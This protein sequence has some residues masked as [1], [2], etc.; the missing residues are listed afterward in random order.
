MILS[1][2]PPSPAGLG[3]TGTVD[4]ANIG[5]ASCD[6]R[7]LQSPAVK[8]VRSCACRHAASTALLS[9][10]RCELRAAGGVISHRRLLSAARGLRPDGDIC[11]WPLATL[12][13]AIRAGLLRNAAWF[14]F[15]GDFG[16]SHWQ[17]PFWSRG[18]WTLPSRFRCCGTSSQK[19]A[20]LKCQAP[21]APQSAA[22]SWALSSGHSGWGRAGLSSRSLSGS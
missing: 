15:N 17:V 19:G 20:R 18:R 7:F 3:V 14:C 2:D 22:G 13:T 11:R 1:A 16:R 9:C 4:A 21:L 8:D 12:L 6:G 10:A 5:R